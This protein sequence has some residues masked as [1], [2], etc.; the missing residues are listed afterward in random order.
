MPVDR[1]RSPV[2]SRAEDC[3]SSVANLSAGMKRLS[4]L[5]IVARIALVFIAVGSDFR[6]LL[7]EDICQFR[8]DILVS[9]LFDG[10]DDM[11]RDV[12]SQLP[13]S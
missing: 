11:C 1:E 10:P 3:P 5:R 2:R 12:L 4:H 8:I 6:D 13:R 7:D 9:A